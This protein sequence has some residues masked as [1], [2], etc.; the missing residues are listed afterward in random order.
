MTTAEVNVR[1]HTAPPETEAPS[2]HRVGADTRRRPTRFSA[3]ALIATVWLSVLSVGCDDSVTPF[4]EGVPDPA[5]V[6]H[7][8][9]DA[10]ADTQFVRVQ[11]V[12]ESRTP[13]TPVLNEL[14][15]SSQGTASGNAVVWRDSLVTLDDG[16]RGHLFFAVYRPIPGE[17]VSLT[18]VGPDS[19]HTTV[20][21]S[22]PIKPT[23]STDAPVFAPNLLLETVRLVGTST[24][25]EELYMQ[26]VVVDPNSAQDR[27]VEI[28]YER[29]FGKPVPSGWEFI[30]N[31]RTDRRSVEAAVAAD[32]GAPLTLRSA[33]IGMIDYGPEWSNRHPSDIGF[34]GTVGRYLIPLEITP[35]VADS[36]SYVLAP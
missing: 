22:I 9:L 3:A 14:Q 13:Q 11:I 29:A 31:L 25:P 32:F 34:V 24:R 19:R 18:A 16:T 10:S 36:L 28:S 1:R 6:L 26:Y 8:I 17:L 2:R 7:G 12:R 21:R 23:L 4:A 20:M 5:H 33:S 30:V 35:A 15:L 27:T